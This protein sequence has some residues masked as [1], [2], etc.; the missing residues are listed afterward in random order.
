MKNSKLAMHIRGLRHL[1]KQEGQVR[2]LILSLS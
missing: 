1:R 2:Q